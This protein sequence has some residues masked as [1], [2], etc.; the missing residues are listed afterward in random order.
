MAANDN[1]VLRQ[2][3][4]GAHLRVTGGQILLARLPDGGIALRVT[5]QPGAGGLQLSAVEAHFLGEQLAPT[6]PGA[7]VSPPPR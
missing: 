5:P 1:L 7:A 4:E 6:A 2:L 3:S